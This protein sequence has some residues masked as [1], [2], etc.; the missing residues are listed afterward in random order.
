MVRIKVNKT[1]TRVRVAF[2][3]VQ[4]VNHKCKIQVVCHLKTLSTTCKTDI[5]A[6]KQNMSSSSDEELDELLRRQIIGQPRNF[7]DDGFLTS[8]IQGN[9]EGS[10]VSLWTTSSTF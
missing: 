10:F 5:G 8:K 2:L 3:Q 4:L 6:S 7:E 9:C 1:F